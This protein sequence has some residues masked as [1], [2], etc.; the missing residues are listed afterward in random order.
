MSMGNVH[1]FSFHIHPSQ[2]LIV[3][4]FSARVQLAAKK[5]L[6]QMSIVVQLNVKMSMGNTDSFSVT[7]YLFGVLILSTWA[8]LAAEKSSL[9]DVYCSPTKCQMSMGNILTIFLSNSTFQV[10]IIIAIFCAWT[11]LSAEKVL[12]M[13]RVLHL[14]VKMSLGNTDNFAVKFY[15]LGF[16]YHSYILC[17]GTTGS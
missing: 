11:Q 10:L 14:N 13:S 4:V 2:V 1:S 8:Q 7:L 5:A 3:L 6:L 9:I 16:N 12:Q 17:L 15:I